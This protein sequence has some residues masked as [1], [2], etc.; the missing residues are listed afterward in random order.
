MTED[1]LIK[2]VVNTILQWSHES[3]QS[4]IENGIPD[5]GTVWSVQD[6]IDDNA[7]NVLTSVRELLGVRHALLQR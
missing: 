6:H 2:T 5:D 4:H 3:F 1:E 7:V